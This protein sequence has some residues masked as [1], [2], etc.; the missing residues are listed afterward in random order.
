MISESRKAI[1]GNWVLDIISYN[2]TG[3][4]SVKLFNDASKDCFEGSTWRFVTNNNRGYYTV[5]D[6]S[7][8]TGE[9]YFIFNVVETEPSAGMYD[10]M[11]KPT[12]EKY[13]SETNAGFR[14]RLAQMSDMMMRWEQTVTLD[15]N[16][17]IISMNFSKLI[18]E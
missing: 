6:A 18:E 12:D 2:E 11:L 4:F 1:K 15:G 7:C 8:Q 13:K 3:H 16:P 14:L 17:F 10:F 9:R 5:E